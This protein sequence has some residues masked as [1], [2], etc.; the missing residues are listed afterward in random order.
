MYQGANA[1]PDTSRQLA[2]LLRS[3]ADQMERGEHEL[4]AGDMKR[5]FALHRL[6]PYT[7]EQDDISSSG[8]CLAE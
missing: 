6:P 3:V 4:R 8:V 1:A 7:P 5:D 2:S